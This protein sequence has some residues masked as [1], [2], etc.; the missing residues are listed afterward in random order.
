MKKLIIASI[1]ALTCLSSTKIVFAGYQAYTNYLLYTNHGNHFTNVH[2]KAT[3]D[4]Y[5]SNRVKSYTGTTEATFWAV[6]GESGSG[7]RVSGFYNQKVGTTS[8]IEFNRN[9]SK[10]AKVQMGMENYK[11]G[12]ARVSGEV[13]FR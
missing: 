2:L 10:D 12:E 1:I 6:S 8:K 13:D 4:Q 7:E 11:D 3:G 9:V 5:I